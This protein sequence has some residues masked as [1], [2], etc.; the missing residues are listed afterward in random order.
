M[1]ADK[2]NG[3]TQQMTRI[4]KRTGGQW[5]D[6]LKIRNGLDSHPGT[7]TFQKMVRLFI[8]EGGSDTLFDLTVTMLLIGEKTPSIS[9]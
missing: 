6:S 5:R 8:Q 7:Q 2:E 3:R 4:E 9:K 1:L